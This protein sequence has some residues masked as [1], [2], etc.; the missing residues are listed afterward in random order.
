MAQDP[1]SDLGRM[2]E[3]GAIVAAVAAPLGLAA[4]IVARGR[5][6]PRWSRPLAPLNRWG[7][8]T[9]P[10]DFGYVLGSC[11]LLSA[12]YPLLIFVGWAGLQ[13]V[14]FFDHL[15]GPLDPAAP[16]TGQLHQLGGVLFAAPVLAGFWLLYRWVVAGR[17]PVSPQTLARDVAFGVVGWFVVTPAVFLVHF[18][19]SVAADWVGVPPD[20]HGLTTLGAGGS[21]EARAVFGLAVC[22]MTPLAE[23]ILFRGLLVGWAGGRWYRPWVLLLLAGG[24]A[25][26]T[27]W[28]GTHGLAPLGFAAALAAG[29]A[30]LSV[31]RAWRSRFPLRTALAV[32]ATAAFFAAAHSAV[33]PTPV[34]LFVLGFGLGYLAARSGG[35]T[36]ST[37]AHGL[38]NAVSFVFLLRG[39]G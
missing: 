20:E 18:L 11:L 30:A 38:F 9:E 8:P 33:W 27:G 25:G 21:L 36:A 19:A 1:Y 24:F 6:L 12:A 4:A 37:V 17:S 13:E 34:P 15:Y 16:A 29:L 7:L 14:G 22:V 28:G 2:A 10:F 35:V 3:A 39:A 26:L 32:Y 31:I 23:E 5:V